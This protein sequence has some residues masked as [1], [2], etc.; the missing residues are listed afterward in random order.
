MAAPPAA[1]RST[2]QTLRR[3]FNDGGFLER[4]QRGELRAVLLR[5]R[6]PSLEGAH[7]PFCTRSQ[8]VA[9]LDANGTRVALVHQYLR[10][11]GSIGGSGLPDPKRILSEGEIL[12]V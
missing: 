5:D 8:A 12:F 10:T 6:H 3:I 11:D 1:R 2:P 4:L 9:Y 7:E